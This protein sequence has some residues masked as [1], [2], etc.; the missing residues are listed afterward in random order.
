MNKRII[1]LIV[2][3][4]LAIVAI[5][6]IHTQ[7]QKREQ[8]IRRLVTEGKLTKVVVATRDI[9]KGSAIGSNEVTLAR[10]PTQDVKPGSVKS[11][12]SVTGKVA[13]VD[14][15]RDQY[16]YSSMVKLRSGRES[17]AERIR[18]RKRAFTVSIDNI[19]AVGGKVQAGDRVDVIA[20]MQI[21]TMRGGKQVAEK[22]VLTLFENIQV[23][24]VG[25]SGKS[26][27]NVTLSLTSE[28]V[29]VINYALEMG[30][31]KLVLRSP[32]EITE[33]GK[34][35]QP[36]TFSSFMQ[37]IYQKMGVQPRAK[38]EL[39]GPEDK[40]PKIEIYRGGE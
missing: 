12:N 9:P 6:I 17:I 25:E 24:T 39:K 35:M 13:T 11:I 18:Q 21:P 37:K 23:L 27:N 20:I 5:V 14:I 10:V 26:I 36:F 3:I 32:S 28:E 2:G 8:V 1:G 31:I 7:L 40:S 29:K 15:I 34:T 38:P 19:S 33:E 16:I 30:K 22:A 4:G